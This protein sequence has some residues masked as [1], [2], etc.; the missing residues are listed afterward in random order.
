MMEHIRTFSK[1]I[2]GYTT[3]PSSV[4]CTDS[5][6]QNILCN[7][8][9]V[10]IAGSLQVADIFE[11]ELI[12]VSGLANYAQLGAFSSLNASGAFGMAVNQFRPAMIYLPTGTFATG[13]VIRRTLGSASRNICINY[14]IV[15]Y[16]PNPIKQISL[17]KGM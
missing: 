7:Y 1:L 15:K 11:L 2:A 10:S 5:A 4:N 6:G 16:N 13:V 12:G 14:G 17:Y 3:T 8:I 9:E